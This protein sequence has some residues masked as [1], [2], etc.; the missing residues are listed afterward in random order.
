MKA[1]TSAPRW[2]TAGSQ[3]GE[4]FMGGQAP[5]LGN[6]SLQEAAAPEAEPVLQDH[7]PAQFKEAP[8]LA[9]TGVVRPQRPGV[10]RRA[11]LEDAGQF[12]S[13]LRDGPKLVVRDT[14]A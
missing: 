3:P 5:E 7:G 8:L 11:E 10:V 13:V 2:L 1:S 4:R 6:G 14:V 9:L 12:G